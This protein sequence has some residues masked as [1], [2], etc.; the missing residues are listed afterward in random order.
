MTAAA[1]LSAA[2]LISIAAEDIPDGENP[3][4]SEEKTELTGSED[5]ESFDY[6]PDLKLNAIDP[7]P[8]EDPQA[9]IYEWPGIQKSNTGK[10]IFL[11]NSNK[12]RYEYRRLAKQKMYKYD[13]FQGAC[14]HGGYSYHILYNRVNQR[15][16]IIKVSFKTHKVVK[17]SASMALDHG[18]DMTYDTA[19][20]R[21]VV[22]HYGKRPMRLTAVDP[23]TLK[24]LFSKNVKKP[25]ERLPGASTAFTKSIS[26]VTGIGYDA[27]ADEYIV[28]IMGA[29]HYMA[30]DPNFKPLRVIKV[31]DKGHYVR[32]GM[33][34]IDG[35]IVRSF[36]ADKKPYNQNIL[37]VYDLA[38]NFIKTVKLGRGFE[39]ESIYFR[40]SRL[41]A[42]TY[43]SYYK[44]I[45]KRRK[46]R[47]IVR[48]RLRRDNNIIRIKNY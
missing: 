43:R 9:P 40:G 4:V 30:I 45:V 41:Y 34:V 2:P 33:T 38:G 17:R 32:Q 3:A 5:V 18:N 37:Y 36:S 7:D 31:P 46:G 22:V 1:V 10:V 28:S 24:I 21:L 16:K 23:V 8:S 14:S 26:G 29:R 13:T 42:S 15:C 35:F 6:D 44:K 25:T 20:D 12:V 27:A 39:I 19:R 47:R 11:K 48:Y